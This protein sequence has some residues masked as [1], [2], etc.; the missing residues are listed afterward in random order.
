VETTPE[1]SAATAKRE[2]RARVLAHRAALPPRELQL[3]GA[4]ISARL[5]ELPALRAARIVAAYIGIGFEVPTD[6]LISDVLATGGTVL[7]PRLEADRSL[8]W[9][10]LTTRSDLVVGRYGLLEPS[11]DVA[12]RPLYD[13]DVVVLPG[14]CYD[15]VGNRLGRGGGSYDRALK[16]LPGTVTAIGI[17]LDGDLVDTVPVESHD[18]PVQII[19]TP[20]RVITV[21]GGGT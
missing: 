19:V 21:D 16:D 8:T 4:A 2:L 15:A 20:S 7:L 1:R 10:P 18:R 17:T 13:A 9:R 5:R 3:A 6:E 12:A 14:L 11:Q